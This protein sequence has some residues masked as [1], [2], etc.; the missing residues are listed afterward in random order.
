MASIDGAQDRIR[1]STVA[2][3]CHYDEYSF[4][5]ET[6]A[7]DQARID[8]IGRTKASEQGAD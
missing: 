8:G 7:Q 3:V 6:S 1:T 5:A 2:Y 4:S